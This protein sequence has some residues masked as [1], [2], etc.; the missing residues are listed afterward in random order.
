MGFNRG[1]VMSEWISVDLAPK[2]GTWIL[3]YSEKAKDFKKLSRRVT[4]WDKKL[5]WG[6]FNSLNWPMTSWM[7]LPSPPK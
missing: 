1:D 3:G 7:P 4:R 5:G 2:D 6:E